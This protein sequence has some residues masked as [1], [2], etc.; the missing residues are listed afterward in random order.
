MLKKTLVFIGFAFWI[1]AAL[2]QSAS[3][4]FKKLQSMLS[5]TNVHSR[6]AITAQAMLVRDSYPGTEEGGKAANIANLLLQ[7]SSIESI[8]NPVA[9]VRPAP[10]KNS[11]ELYYQDPITDS[12]FYRHKDVPSLFYALEIKL[13]T[14]NGKP[15]F[16]LSTGYTGESWIFFKEIHARCGEK[17]FV[18][19]LP[20]KDA[21]RD[22]GRGSVYESIDVPLSGKARELATC[23]S[24]NP[25]KK[26][27]RLSG[28]YSETTH[29]S[30]DAAHALADMLY[31]QKNW[32]KIN[33]D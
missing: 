32:K 25:D 21:Y 26:V 18:L 10:S 30:D 7:G 29:I 19:S 28:K 23:I 9:N 6:D 16:Y 8:L 14:V 4:D 1:N 3:E 5:S 2:A 15:K 27:V 17:T 20:Y 13:E 31:L 22:V 12:K 11:L 33:L 24:K